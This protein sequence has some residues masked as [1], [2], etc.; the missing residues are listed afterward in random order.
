MDG[1]PSSEIRRVSPARLGVNRVNVPVVSESELQ[2]TETEEG[3][4][5]EEKRRVKKES[6]KTEKKEWGGEGEE[7]SGG[8]YGDGVGTRWLRHKSK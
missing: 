8:G 2:L 7:G 6:R 4:Q 1:H 5:R 3:K